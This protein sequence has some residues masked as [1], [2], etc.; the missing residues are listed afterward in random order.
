MRLGEVS[1]QGA[2]VREVT[3]AREKMWGLVSVRTEEHKSQPAKLWNAS[4]IFSL[5]FFFNHTEWMRH[6]MSRC[7]GHA[8]EDRRWL[9]VQFTPVSAHFKHT[10]WSVRTGQKN[11]DCGVSA[12]LETSFELRRSGHRCRAPIKPPCKASARR[13]A[14]AHTHTLAFV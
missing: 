2:T 14:R 3:A 9:C 6:L 8:R 11:F 13:G 10:N 1:A 12:S 4:P 5:F 7:W